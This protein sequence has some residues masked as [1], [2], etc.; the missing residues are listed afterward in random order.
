MRFLNV[1][2]CGMSMGLQMQTHAQTFNTR[3]DPWERADF[4]WC[5]E[6]LADSSYMV[7]SNSEWQDSLFYSSVV[8][9]VRTNDTGA[10]LDTS[11]LSIPLRAT[12]VGWAN[13]SAMCSDGRI[14][15]GGNTYRS[16]ETIQA[17][18]FITGTD[19][20]FSQLLVYGAQGEEWIGRQAKQTPDGGYVLCGETS[21]VGIVDG[22]LVKTDSAG[23]VE[24]VRTYGSDDRY[25]F[26]TSVDLAPWGGYYVGGTR[27]VASGNYDPWILRMDEEGNIIGQGDH[28]TPQNDYQS[29]HLTTAADGHVLMACAL[30]MGSTQNTQRIGLLKMDQEGVVQWQR[31]YGAVRN[32]ALFVV[33]EIAPSYD[34]ITCG[35]AY[36]G[37]QPKGILLRTTATGDSLW[38]REYDY[39]DAE[40]TNGKG[41][42]YD[43]QPTPDGG[44]IAVGVALAVA[45]QYTQDVWVVKTDSMGC[46]EPGCHLIT[47]MESQIT[48]LKDA[49]RVWPNPVAQGGAV[50]VSVEL[51]SNFVVQGQLRLTVTDALGRLV[52]EQV[53]AQGTTTLNFINT[54]LTT[55]LY[56]LHL[57][58][59][60]RWI[61]GGKLLVE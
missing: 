10:F 31:L 20:T 16:D 3:F 58:D 4:G 53:V 36:I 26:Y 5:V 23:E 30:N 15:I 28:G 33:Q 24:W 61:S 14:V 47:G 54:Q 43:V 34:L 17:A 45:G 56:H 21:T 37:S 57:S 22:F 51:P 11:R 50:Q 6:R 2:V 49:L 41:A 12:Y 52:Q 59:D 46:I 27:Q 29:A 7:I 39:F 19:G 13:A 9:G 1:V 40:V 35:F 55:G 25:E 42:F 44:F 32:T 38:M 8:T 48:N 60:R 18:L